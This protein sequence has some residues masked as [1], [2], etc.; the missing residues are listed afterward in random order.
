MRYIFTPYYACA[1]CRFFLHHKPCAELR[2]RMRHP[3]HEHSLMLLPRSTYASGSFGCDACDRSCNGFT[4]NCKECKFDLDVQCSLLPYNKFTHDSHEH[5]LILSRS[6]EVDRKC[7]NCDSDKG[8]KF[9]C[10]DNCGFA[11]D[12]KCLTLPHT[13]WY[14]QHEHPFTLCYAPEDDSNEYYCD[15][16]EEEQDPRCWFYYCA[17]CIYPAHP[18]CILEEFPNKKFGKT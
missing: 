5:G 15:I 7:N 6:Q 3:L 12:F 14:E 11:L 8:I 1:Q 17:D 10:A 18:E 16:C 2:R 4:Y 9:C 13:V